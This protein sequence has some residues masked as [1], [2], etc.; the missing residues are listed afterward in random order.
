MQIAV[1]QVSSESLSLRWDTPAGEV[2]SYIVTCCHEGDVVEE[3][4]D[5]N[6]LTLRNLKPGVCY[7]LLVS[8]QLRNGRISKLAGTSAKTSK[9]NIIIIAKN[10]QNNAR[11]VR[12]IYRFFTRTL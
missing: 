4:T 10:F 12:A 1:Y 8:T 7:S 3:S 2:E 11:D 9:S 5:T 6:N